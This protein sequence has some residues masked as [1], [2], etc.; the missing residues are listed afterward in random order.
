MV[1]EARAV[2]A[3]DFCVDALP[4]LFGLQIGLLLRLVCTY[5]AY[6][7]SQ[8]TATLQSGPKERTMYICTIYAEHDRGQLA[9]PV[10][11]F[12]IL[13]CLTYVCRMCRM[14][15]SFHCRCTNSSH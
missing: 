11:V 5:N 1:S 12:K 2:F 4:V 9:L 10:P 14:C 3:V 15:S 7:T 8:P 13:N 6:R